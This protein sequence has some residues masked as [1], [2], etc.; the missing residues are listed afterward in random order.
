MDNYSMELFGVIRCCFLI[1]PSWNRSRIII[2][3]HVCI[4]PYVHKLFNLFHTSPLMKH[5]PLLLKSILDED[6]SF[7]SNLISDA[8][9]SDITLTKGIG[10]T[11]NW[12]WSPNSDP[13]IHEHQTW[14]SL[15]ISYISW[16]SRCR[17][18]TI[19]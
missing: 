3:M 4:M 19:L 14:P 1:G 6:S 5:Y 11:T 7:C 9:T 17:L 16:I 12:Q 10:I 18:Q 2:W 8:E 13:N 15:P